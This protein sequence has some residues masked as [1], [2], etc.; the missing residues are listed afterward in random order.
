VFDDIQRLS[1]ECRYRDCRHAD[2][3]G[4]AVRTGVPAERLRS[5][6]KLLRESRRDTL[7]ALERRAQVSAWKARG[8]HA[9]MIAKAKRG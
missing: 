8:R 6:Q 7:S 4:C 5:F 2:E 1:S 9:K 3:P